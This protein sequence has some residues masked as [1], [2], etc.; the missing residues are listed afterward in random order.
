MP[1]IRQ[2]GDAKVNAPGPI[3]QMRVSPDDLGAAQGRALSSLGESV[4]SV[5]EVVAKRLDQENTSDVT[6]KLT[7]ANA[8]LAVK[9][10]QTLRTAEPGDKK[11][12]EDYQKE[13]DDKLGAIGDQATS[14]TA[15]KFYEETSAHIKGQLYKTSADG[16]ADLAGTKAVADYKTALN[17][18]STTV[19]ADPTSVGLQQQIHAQAINNLVATGQLPR[20]K[21]IE[22]QTKGD[23]EI[24][25]AAV[26]GWTNLNP[27]Y[28]KQKLTGGE[29]DKYL[30]AD[31]K[32]MLYG[33]IDTA[34]RAKDI[35][36][37]RQQRLADK[38]LQKQQTQTQ[39]TF[40]QGINDGTTSAKD[41]LNSNLEPTGGGSKE[42]FLQI[43]KRANES[44]EKLKTDPGTMIALMQR[45]HLPDGDPKKLVDENELNDYFGK[46]LSFHDLNSLRDEMQGKQTE[47]GKIESEMKKQ[48]F[49][50][51]KGKL[52]KS[53]PLTGLRDPVGD[54]QL[55]K[56]QSAFFE[57]YKQ[58]R[59][60]GESARELLDPSSSKYLGSNISQY[61]RS[62]QQIMRDLVP[63]RSAPEQTLS[64]NPATPNTQSAGADQAP[65][66]YQAPK[67][68]PVPRLPNESP[69]DYLKR[70]K[71][72]GG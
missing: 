71:A 38:V 33:E 7:K 18:I 9:L 25:Q 20:D 16:Q 67:S 22:L 30:D 70:K 40:L 1:V 4:Q 48:V 69:E 62:Q 26:R 31:H 5:G 55:A 58:R 68:A 45:I 49:E 63:R 43:L 46:G 54:E 6:A 64:G 39:N 23:Q 34:K 36:L 11:P 53:N 27:D 15:R 37:E 8:E 2:Y 14:T 3:Q 28:A 72:A 35:E 65:V 50:I 57:E 32:H 44:E 19:L 17:S 60:K 61:V 24:A 12:F 56:W 52:T 41:I 51:A 66:R 13:V 29:F 21:A 47:A 10:Q 59:A 42:Q